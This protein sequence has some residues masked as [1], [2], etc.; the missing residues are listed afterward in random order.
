[1]KAAVP[2]YMRDMNQA[3][4]GHRFGLYFPIWN[5]RWEM[6]RE[7]K[8]KA[9]ATVLS[10]QPDD[11][12]RMTALAERQQLQA[13]KL[14]DAVHSE[15]AVATAPF[16]TGMGYGHPLENGFAFLNPYGLP[17]LP[18]S[19][20]KGVLRRA[21]EE[22]EVDVGVVDEMFGSS[23]A[24][25]SQGALN[26]WDVFPQGELALDIMTPHHTGYYQGTASPHDSESP[27][28]IPFLTVAPGAQFVFHVQLIRPSGIL[29]WQI[30]LKQ[31]FS[32][33]F[34]W[35]GFGAK[36]AV[37]Y[38]AMA[39]D[40]KAQE[41]AGTARIKAEEEAR[42]AAMSPLDRDID[43]WKKLDSNHRESQ[44]SAWVRRMDETE[45]PET[46]QIAKM[47]RTYLQETNSWAIK[48]KGA[49][50]ERARKVKD[51][52]QRSGCL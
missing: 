26:F 19:S 36:T 48:K 31:C 51:V 4:P 23:A 15:Y 33:A 46:L 7:G 47:L 6:H 40:E 42:Q 11:K 8:T 45:D 1:M 39:V 5:D 20:I 30:M 12:K 32:H 21:A 3:A 37:G 44:V 52:L 38:G 10:L 17:Y 35:L 16:V 43:I 27:V 2:Q 41:H 29:D 25:G 34:D 9:A 13:L 24:D 22:L 49:K 14:G 18:G 28:P 50:K